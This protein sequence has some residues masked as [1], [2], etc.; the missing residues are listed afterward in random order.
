MDVGPMMNALAD[1]R[2]LGETGEVLVGIRD[3]ETMRLPLP[4]SPDAR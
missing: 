2:R 4:S 3:H 1:P